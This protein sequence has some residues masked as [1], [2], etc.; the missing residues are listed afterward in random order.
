MK[1]HESEDARKE[2]NT[3]IKKERLNN[4]MKFFLIFMALLAGFLLLTLGL[5]Y[6]DLKIHPWV[7][8]SPWSW[9]ILMSRHALAIAFHHGKYWVHAVLSILLSVA[10]AYSWSRKAEKAG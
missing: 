4:L 10:V 8:D 7:K 5:S 2:M 3:R 9:W 6:G 1:A